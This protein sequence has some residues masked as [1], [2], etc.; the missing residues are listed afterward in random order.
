[1][2]VTLRRPGAGCLLA[3]AVAGPVL[4]QNAE[5]PPPVRR[6]IEQLRH[7]IEALRQQ[8]DQRVAELEARVAALQASPAGQ[9]VASPAGSPP[10]VES[11]GSPPAS[12]PV[13]GT[14][15]A[16]GRIFNPDIAVIGDV[17]GAAGHDR[18]AP[19]P[20]IDLHEAEASFQAIV[21]PYA[22]AD[23]F[24]AFGAAGVEIEEA[25]VTFPA[26]PGGLL[27]RAGRMRSA[28][29]K[30]NTLH[31]HALPW[32]DRPLVTTNLLGGE[33][34]IS[35]AGVSF[36]RLVPNPWLFLEATGQIFAG[37]AEGVFASAR[38]REVS[39]LGHLRAYRDLS[40]S[41]N[42]DLGASYARGYNDAG[43]LAS[44]DVDR[45][46]TSLFGIDATV[47][48]KPLRRSIYR[49]FVGR[50]EAAWSRRGQFGGPQ[51]A[52]G[53][54]ASGD[55]QFARR[56]FAGLRIDRSGRPGEGLLVDTGRSVVVTFWPSEF[57]QVRGQYRQTR[58]AGEMSGHELRVQLQ[59]AIGVHG[60]HPF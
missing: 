45:F 18:V 17:L 15:A 23:V 30:V 50:T 46:T 24:F 42:L 31:M 8:Y 1:M 22:R 28:F 20:A 56:W 57:S 4:A 29:G 51:H 39:Y 47:R 36:A 25:Y 11:T 12:L 7:D 26:L 58:Y 21:D 55:Y 2:R 60:A 34:G 13:Y 49:S 3:L 9:A 6:E 37:T 5:A 14:A 32:T 52:F 59:F 10:L 40:E 38:P 54:Y 43:G 48:W 27:A 33:E 41:T 35:D 44:G 53:Y 16:G 19:G